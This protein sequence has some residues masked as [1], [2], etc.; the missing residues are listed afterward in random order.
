MCCIPVIFS[1]YIS[2]VLAI[3][4]TVLLIVLVVMVLIG[5]TFSAFSVDS[6]HVDMPG[7]HM[8]LHLQVC[9]A[10]NLID[11]AV[12]SFK[13]ALELEPNDGLSPCLH[14]LLLLFCSHLRPLDFVLTFFRRN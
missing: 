9:M 11:A 14:H 3:A 5:L 13:Q 10:L 1:L 2:I 12:E 7:F 8:V 4:D 6:Y